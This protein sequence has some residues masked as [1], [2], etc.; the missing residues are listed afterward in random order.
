[1]EALAGSSTIIAVAIALLLLT[2]KATRKSVGG[3]VEE[4]AKYSQQSIIIGRASAYAEAKEELGDIK[5]LIDESNELLKDV[6]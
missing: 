2:N 3:S 6:K 4:G 1:M 5:T